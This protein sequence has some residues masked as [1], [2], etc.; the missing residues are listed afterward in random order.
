[1][2]PRTCAWSQS[3]KG[4][5]KVS[6]GE[7]LM[8]SGQAMNDSVGRQAESKPLERRVC[9]ETKESCLPHR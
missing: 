2:G 5:W 9:S 6:E 8:L 7:A 3:S 4:L 1:M